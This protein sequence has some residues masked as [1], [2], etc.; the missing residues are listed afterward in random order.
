MV[1]THVCQISAKSGKNWQF[2]KIDLDL[3]IF[4]LQRLER[5]LIEDQMRHSYLI[6]NWSENISVPIRSLYDDRFKSYAHFYE[7]WVCIFRDLDLDSIFTKYI[8]YRAAG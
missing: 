5:S 7:N 2:W 6:E 8:G 1:H 3:Y 4:D